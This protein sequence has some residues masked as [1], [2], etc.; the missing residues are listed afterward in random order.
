MVLDDPTT[1]K[2]AQLRGILR[3]RGLPIYGRKAELI[4]RM[5]A[6]DPTGS[7]VQQA[8][9]HRDQDDDSEEEMQA[10]AVNVQAEPAIERDEERIRHRETELE[11]RERELMRREIEF[12]RREN[13][14]LRASPRSGTSSTA[15]RATINIK[16]V[17]DLLNEYNGS[18]E[19]FERWRA[20][21]NLLCQLYELDDNAAKILVGSKLRGKALEWYRSRA[22][23]LSMNLD[24]LFGEMEP[25]FNQPMGKLE[26]RRKFEN[27]KWQRR[28]E[29]KRRV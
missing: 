8:A 23:Y 29:I 7:W 28:V 6:V 20:Q 12:L 2:L 9:E 21:V 14:V 10:A 22:E 1:L 19:D 25:M 5:Q 24:E 4:L 18:G 16:N 13:E 11:E 26:S 15:S 27:R 3:H 17:G